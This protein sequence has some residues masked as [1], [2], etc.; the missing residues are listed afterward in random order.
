MFHWFHIEASQL[1]SGNSD[2]GFGTFK[3]HV[4]ALTLVVREI[5]RHVV[6]H[7]ALF[8]ADMVFDELFQYTVAA[9]VVRLSSKRC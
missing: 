7:V 4:H 2:S 6:P 5:L 8:L 9:E 1:G 3:C